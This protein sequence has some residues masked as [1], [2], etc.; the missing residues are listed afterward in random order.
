M[1][2]DMSLGM[3]NSC[4]DCNNI[5]NTRILPYSHTFQDEIN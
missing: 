5:S 3:K 4:E 2:N 1:G